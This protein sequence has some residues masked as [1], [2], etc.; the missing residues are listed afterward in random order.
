MNH[1]RCRR[2]R[3]VD[4]SR[5][6]LAMSDQFD[7]VVIGAGQAGPSLAVRLAQSGRRTAIVE[8]KALGGTC[9]NTGCTPTK[10]LIASARA[11]HVSRRAADYGVSLGGPVLVAIKKVKARKA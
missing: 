3:R 4:L 9:V 8:R 7:A 11:A 2:P 1:R 5:K 6:E 10:T